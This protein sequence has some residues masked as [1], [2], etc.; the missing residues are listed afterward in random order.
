MYEVLLGLGVGAV[1]GIVAYTLIGMIKKPVKLSPAKFRNINILAIFVMV[2]VFYWLENLAPALI[3]AIIT[4]YLPH[5]IAYYKNKRY[6]SKVLEQLSSAVSLFT[7]TLTVTKNIPRAIETVGLRIH[8]PVGSVFRN[9]YAELTFNTPLEQVS[10][11]IAKKLDLSY[12]YIF[13]KLLRSAETQG[14][15]I[16]PLFRDL[17]YKINSARDQQNF[18]ITEVSAVRITNI[19]LMALPI[20][21]YLL[22][23][24]KFEEMSI[25]ATSTAGRVIC[26][27]WL[28][29]IILW[30]FMDR[31]ITDS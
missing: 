28:L 18:Q 25:F 1:I 12:G 9:A 16:T 10:E 24:S 23:S 13:A 3:A 14:D 5:Q 6:R 11:S 2:I 31:L 29:A 26:T 21:T 4:V 20:P 19:I 7:N 17:S 8:D 15:T 30:M 27:L 22:L